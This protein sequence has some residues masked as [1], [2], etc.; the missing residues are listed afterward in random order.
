MN[1]NS[2]QF[3]S[4]EWLWLAAGAAV[5]FVVLYGYSAQRRRGQ[6]RQFAADDLLEQL[7][8]GHS[9]LKRFIK[10]TLLLLAVILLS[11]SLARPQWG[12]TQEERNNE[13]ED[14]L[15]LLDTSKSMLAR[16]VEPS[17]LERAKLAIRDFT[18]RHARGRIGILAFA[19]S[20]F[21]QC[22][23]TFDYEAFDEAVR[24]LNIDSVP[25]PGTDIS[26]ALL[27]SK[28]AFEKGDNR[29]VVVLLTDGED[30][31]KAGIKTAEAIAKD[32]VV[33]YCIGIGTEAGGTVM[34]PQEN[35]EI[36]PMIDSSGQ[37]IVSKLDEETLRRIAT[38][39]G[40]TYRRLDQ[41]GAVMN[42]IAQTL[43]SR[44]GKAAATPS[45]KRGIDR[46]Q[47][48]LAVAIF[49]LVVESLLGTRRKTR[50]SDTLVSV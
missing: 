24:D 28:K 48:P 20:A 13:G 27:V 12:Q 31:E 49:L 34:V 8:R 47:W 21:L 18:H 50:Q 3:A 39:S 43:Q 45:K 5:L 36:G 19:G 44:A 29:K 41:V 4:P 6:L 15:F 10:N 7:L 9:P 32:G 14:I 25:L 17:R 11:L 30:L 16:D 2:F 38:A 1:F 46:Y 33:I 22:P 40:G 26:K 35:G 37:T 42:D 23:L